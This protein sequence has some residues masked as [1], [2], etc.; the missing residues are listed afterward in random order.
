[1]IRV[2]RASLVDVVAIAGASLVEVGRWL[3]ELLVRHDEPND[4]GGD[5]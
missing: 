5:D 3:V 4:L 2:W 1:M